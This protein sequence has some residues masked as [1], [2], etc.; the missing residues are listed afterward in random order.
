MKIERVN[1]MKKIKLGLLAL[2]TLFIT[3]C[4]KQIVDLQYKYKSAI[5]TFDGW[6]TSQCYE[7]KK[8][9]DYEGEQLQLTL[10]DG[11]VILISSINAILISSTCS[12]IINE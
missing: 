12:A 4:N 11:T 9:T 2:I 7:L 3:S 1:K 10:K 6:K 5:L 8:W